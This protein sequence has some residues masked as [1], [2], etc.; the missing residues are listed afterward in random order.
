[1]D[2]QIIKN[3]FKINKEKKI[4][5][6][7]FIVEGLKTE[8]ILLHKIFKNIFGYTYEKLDRNGKYRKYSSKI[9]EHSSIFVINTQESNIKFINDSNEYLNNLFEKLIDEYHFPVDKASIFYIFDRDVKSNTN[10]ELVKGLMDV[11]TNSR[12]NDGFTR[13]GLLLL[14][15][16]SI[17][18]YTASN[19]IPDTY[20]LEFDTG[21]L[22][23]NY[24]HEN[25]IIQNKINEETICFAVNQMN[26]YFESIQVNTY[27]IDNFKDTNLKVFSAQEECYSSFEKYQLLSLLSIAFIDLGMIEVQEG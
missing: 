7:L 10:N 27:D 6:V 24:L 25:K 22:L 3:N 20:K 2:C 17:E 18:S 9:N 1:M 4:G 23:K 8:F 11:L 19:F 14:S 5:K 16:P 15:Y 21:D 26:K 13:Q 12:D